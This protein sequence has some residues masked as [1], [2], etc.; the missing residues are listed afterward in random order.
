[1]TIPSSYSLSVPVI[2][3]FTE[4]QELSPTVVGLTAVPGR[5]SGL[6][7]MR[8]DT[9]EHKSLAQRSVYQML[10]SHLPSSF[11]IPERRR[12]LFNP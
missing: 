6:V 3:S 12:H 9:Q 2:H 11:L 10:G 4:E 7:L 8:C 1:M 5:S